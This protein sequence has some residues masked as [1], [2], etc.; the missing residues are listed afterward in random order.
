MSVSDGQGADQTTFNNAFMSKATDSTTVG[1]QTLNNADVASGTQVINQ[2]TE[3]NSAASY[4]GKAINALKDILPSWS[5]T[6]VGT[7]T[8]NL[9][10]R[11]E[12]LT[13]QVGA[14][15]VGIA[16]RQLLSEKSANDGY[17]SL[18]S[19]GIVPLAELPSFLAVETQQTINDND[20]EDLTGL[21][22]DKTIQVVAKIEFTV[23]RGS[24]RTVGTLQIFFR[25]GGW[26]RMLDIGG[27]DVGV[28]LNVDSTTG[29][30]SYTSTSTG[31]AGKIKHRIVN[32]FN[33]E[34]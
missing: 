34:T 12:A 10:Q 25:T 29:Q 14:N 21:L 19:S 1:K 5:S 9:T 15:E 4:I 11:A 32:T 33:L 20:T 27:D 6:S 17:A 31:T 23:V 7:G 26:D 13:V 8:D 16:L 18:D 3:Q 2:Q 28:V 30:V 24:D 22:F